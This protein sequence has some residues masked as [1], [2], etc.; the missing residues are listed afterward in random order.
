MT[1]DRPYVSMPAFP[2]SQLRNLFASAEVSEADAGVGDRG[3]MSIP[4]SLSFV[5]PTL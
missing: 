5:F 3:R 1:Y 2:L 4:S